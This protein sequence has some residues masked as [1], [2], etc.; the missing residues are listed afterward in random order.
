MMMN[1]FVG[2]LAAILGASLVQ[3]ILWL[4]YRSKRKKENAAFA[5]MERHSK[6]A[7]EALIKHHWEAYEYHM[8]EAAKYFGEK[9]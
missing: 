7:S 4:R 1:F 5:E 2:L 8:K 9:K 3:G 6:A